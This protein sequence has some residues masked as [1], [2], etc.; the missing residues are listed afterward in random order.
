MRPV[1]THVGEEAPIAKGLAGNRKPLG[2]Q[3]YRRPTAAA[4]FAA[5]AVETGLVGPGIGHRLPGN[6]TRIGLEAAAVAADSRPVPGKLAD[7]SKLRQ[8]EIPWRRA[9]QQR[10]VAAEERSAGSTAEAE[11]AEL[12]SDCIVRTVAE[13]GSSQESY[14]KW[15]LVE[16]PKQEAKGAETVEQRP[17][18]TAK[19]E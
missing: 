3:S 4:E 11:T 19:R 2:V 9:K 18:L 16:R 15:K 8:S 13:R 6:G 12:G 1:L 5:A 17:G 7:R 14:R 10:S